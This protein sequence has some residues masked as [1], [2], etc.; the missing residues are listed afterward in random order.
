[1]KIGPPRG[2]GLSSTTTTPQ[3]LIVQTS[4]EAEQCRKCPIP[5][6]LREKKSENDPGYGIRIDNPY[7]IHDAESESV[8]KLV[9]RRPSKSTDLI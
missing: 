4:G 1:L 8:P 5:Q 2:Q 9:V 7:L 3:T 6:F